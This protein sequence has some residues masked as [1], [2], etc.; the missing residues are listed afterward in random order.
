[1]NNNTFTI[2][3]ET[4]AKALFDNYESIYMIDAET[5]EWKAL[6]ESAKYHEYK[7]KKEGRHFYEDAMPNIKRVICKEDLSYVIKMLNKEAVA[8]GIKNKKYYGFVYRIKGGDKGV[9]HQIRATASSIDGKEYVLMGIRNI[10]S[11]VRQELSHRREIATLENKERNHLEAILSSAAGYMEINLSTD[12]ILDKNL[13]LSKFLGNTILLMTKPDGTMNYSD[14]QDILARH[15]ISSGERRY[16]KISSVEYLMNCFVRNERRASVSFT[17]QNYRGEVYPFREVFYLYRDD[18]SGEVFAFAVF[19]DLTE[20][21][22]KEKER[23][24]LK[25]LLKMSRIRNFT[26]QMEP[27]FLYNALGSIQ[28]IIYLNPE[29]AAELIENFALHL[30]GCLNALKSDDPIPFRDELDNIRAYVNIEKVRFGDKLKVNFDIKDFEFN[31]LPL[32]I[33]P[34]VE[35]AIRHGIY[36]RGEKGGTVALETHSDKKAFYV[37][38]RDDG[39]GFQAPPQSTAFNT[40]YSEPKTTI[41]NVIFRLKNILKADVNIKSTKGK[42]SVVTIRIPRE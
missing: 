24:E 25:E 4:I 38:I 11:T 34:F 23:A 15:L 36:E 1:M 17:I 39:V 7:I 19:Y 21:Q 27:H 29:Y 14:T 18:S 10:D 41:E 2:P 30:K 3:Y 33:E 22:R 32:S 5:C 42:G 37:V 26:A 12:T 16:L 40:V 35:N 31:V 6:Y 8:E 28:E 9:Y 20:E 13:N